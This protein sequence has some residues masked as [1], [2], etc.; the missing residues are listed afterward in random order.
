MS[1]R[2]SIAAIKP[3]G[4]FGLELLQEKAGSKC[5]LREFRRM[6]REVVEADTLPDYRMFWTTPTRLFSTSR[7]PPLI[8]RDRQI[9]D[10]LTHQGEPA[11][12][13][14]CFHPQAHRTACCAIAHACGLGLFL[15]PTFCCG[16]ACAITPK[17]IVLSPTDSKK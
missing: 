14:L 7:P 16:W 15:S 9:C 11:G 6:V 17:P 8:C 3:C 1:W 4:A 5:S 12:K 10:G 13:L 2:A